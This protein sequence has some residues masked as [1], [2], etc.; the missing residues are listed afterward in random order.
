MS[1]S[2]IRHDRDTT[3]STKTIAEVLN[4]IPPQFLH[5]FGQARETSKTSARSSAQPFFHRCGGVPVRVSPV[6]I[7]L[8]LHTP[9]VRW[10]YQQ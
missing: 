10:A 2:A 6:V 4:P 3:I 7:A 1:E 5:T 9:R 8:F